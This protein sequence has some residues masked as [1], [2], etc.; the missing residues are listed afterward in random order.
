MTVVT[1]TGVAATTATSLAGATA[2]TGSTT[3]GLI[4]A[5]ALVVGVTGVLIAES[6]EIIPCKFPIL[7]YCDLALVLT[8]LVATRTTAGT[9]G[10]G[11]GLGGGHGLDS[12]LGGARGV[13]VYRLDGAGRV[14]GVSL[15]I[16]ACNFLFRLAHVPR[17]KQCFSLQSGRRGE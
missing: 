4:G 15:D 3:G 11:D 6:C 5:S 7:I 12:A 14:V 2:T 1:L 8:S 13:L 16:I 9:G 10:S 17:S